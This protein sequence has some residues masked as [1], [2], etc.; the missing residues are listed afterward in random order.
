MPPCVPAHVQATPCARGRVFISGRIEGWRE[1]RGDGDADPSRS[2]TAWM[3]EKY[4]LRPEQ[5]PPPPSP[6]FLLDALMMVLV[7]DQL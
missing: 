3:S 7:V 4:Q 5:L 2:Q 6:T 1:T